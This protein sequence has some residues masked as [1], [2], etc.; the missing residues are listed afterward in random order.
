MCRIVSFVHNSCIE[1]LP[2]VPQNMAVCRKSNYFPLNVT[3][4]ITHFDN[5]AAISYLGVLQCTLRFNG[6]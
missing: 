6:L 2:P 5:N 3:N 1:A 4:S